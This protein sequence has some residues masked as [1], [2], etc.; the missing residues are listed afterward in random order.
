MARAI[1]FVRTSAWHLVLVH[2]VCHEER[3]HVTLKHVA[4]VD[5]IGELCF[6]FVI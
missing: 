6:I 2:E 5:S 4:E 1:K 3:Q